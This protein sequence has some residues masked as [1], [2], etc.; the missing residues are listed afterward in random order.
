ML[1]VLRP[2]EAQERK[3]SEVRVVIANRMRVC[4]KAGDTPPSCSRSRNVGAGALLVSSRWQP[5]CWM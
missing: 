1:A 3:V 4:R 5:R 2:D